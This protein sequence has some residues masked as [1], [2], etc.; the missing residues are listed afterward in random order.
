MT[1][2]ESI[3]ADWRPTPSEILLLRAALLDGEAA[4][5]AWED[6]RTRA[7]RPLRAGSQRLLPAAYLNLRESVPP[8]PWLEV[9]K[10]EYLRARYTNLLRFDD[11]API[12]GEFR[13]DGVTFLLLKGAALV[14]AHYGDPGMR[15]MVDLD[16]MVK[17]ED[18]ERAIA[19]LRGHGYTPAGPVDAAVRA[20]VHS[21]P[22]ARPAAPP[23]D[24]HWRASE[25]EEDR[26]VWGRVIETRYQGV[27]VRVPGPADL[28]LQACV[29]GS[30]WDWDAPQRWVLDAMAVLR[31]SGDCLDWPA[32]IAGAISMRLSTSVH[33]SLR[34]LREE[35]GAAIPGEVLGALA[36]A[37]A[38]RWERQAA[39]ARRVRPDLRG[40]IM[41]F[42]LR[43]DEHRRL[44]RR[45]VA[46][47][48]VWGLLHV[49]RRSWDLPGLWLLPLHAAFRGAR[50]ALQLA[51]HGLRG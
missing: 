9:A 29:T 26:A 27:M 25:L 11:A 16:V 8:D 40:P 18:A 17:E 19:I 13:E 46:R 31:S 45:G 12:L 5:T 38:S 36:A 42:A 37:P 22:F 48:G 24:L 20:V 35:F 23:F 32:L 47:G 41:A 39:R 30:S 10:T 50:R 2:S 14:A 21:I 1:P 33:D 44:V 51:K 4:Q 43:L 7:S 6:W 15:P 28:L 3:P 34:F 49:W